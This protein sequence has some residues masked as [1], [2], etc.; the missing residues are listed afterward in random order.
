MG[1]SPETSERKDAV[2][3]RQL[4][5]LSPYD[6]RQHIRK[7]RYSGQTAGL[8]AG[9]LQGNI[10]IV[11]ASHAENFETFCRNNPKPCPLVGMTEAG[12]P[13]LR[14]LGRDV[15]I[16]TDVPAY[17]IYRGGVLDARATSLLDIWTDDLVAFVL[18]CSFSFEEAL[19]HEGISLRHIDENKTVSMFRTTIPTVAAGPFVGPLVVSMR[20]L[21]PNDID[22]AVEITREFP[23]AHG[24]PVHIGDPAAI[25]IRDIA[26]PDWGDATRFED[27]EVPVFWA[28][29][30]T[31]QAAIE[32]AELPVFISHAPGHMLVT[33]LAS[34]DP[35]CL[36][37]ST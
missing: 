14:R 27:G 16:R 17:N 3:Y 30:V 24:A 31:P 12:N 19:I 20:P 21:D 26:T 15:D 9:H 18:G 33:D 7:G 37:P 25:G 32:A 35:A 34:D 6:V 13:I 22:R 8:G 28:C 36:L 4:S 29:G 5:S 23:Q 2:S 10:A 11:P 1:Q